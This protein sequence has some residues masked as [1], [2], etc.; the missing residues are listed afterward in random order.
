[1]AHVVGGD[2]AIATLLRSARNVIVLGYSSK[3]GRPSNNVS[4]Y[5]VDIA[6]YRVIGVNPVQDGSGPQQQGG[7]TASLIVV[8]TLAAAASAIGASEPNTI[9]IVDVFRNPAALPEVLQEIKSL[10]VKP[11]AVWLQEGVAHPAVEAELRAMD[12]FVIADRCIL[13]EHER[14]LGSG[15]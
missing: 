2:A 7:R 1:M 9:D 10:S 6:R 15:L 3:L 13:K 11:R 5:L 12:I 4:Q 14:L 8:P